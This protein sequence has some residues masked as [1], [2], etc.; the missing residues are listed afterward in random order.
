MAGI[1]AAFDLLDGDLRD[2]NP[3]GEFGLRKLQAL[4]ALFDSGGESGGVHGRIL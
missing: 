1:A 3:F 4:S 2:P